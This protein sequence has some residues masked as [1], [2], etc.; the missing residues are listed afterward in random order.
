MECFIRRGEKCLAEIKN[1][2]HLLIYSNRKSRPA[3]PCADRLFDLWG[4]FRLPG[5]AA[6]SAI[7]LPLRVAEIIYKKRPARNP[8]PG[9]PFSLQNLQ[10]S[11]TRLRLAR[12]SAC[13]H[14]RLASVDN[15]ALIP[16]QPGIRPATETDS[17][18]L[19]F[20]LP[21]ITALYY[22]NVHRCQAGVTDTGMR[23]RS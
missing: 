10:I 18:A 11:K 4:S 21:C 5:S 9:R 2:R 6:S 8:I 14:N 1:S 16:D 12:G 19:H 17:A 3:L 13:L 20:G 7:G 15:G 23:S 22:Y